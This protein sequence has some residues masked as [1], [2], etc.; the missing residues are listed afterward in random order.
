[1]KAKIP[2]CTI[3]LSILTFL[4]SFYV[5]YDISGFFFGDVKIVQLEKYGGVTFSHIADFEIWR[6]FMSQVIHV[7]QIHMLYNV[8]SLFIIGTYIERHLGSVRLLMLWLLSGISGTLI[9]TLFVS[10]PWNLGTGGSQAIMGLAAAGAVLI[11]RR[12]DS[13]GLKIATG[14]A[15]LPAISLDIVF[16]HYPKPGHVFGFLVGIGVC[17]FF[18]NGLSKEQIR[19]KGQVG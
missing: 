19:N 6:L 13:I 3:I 4:V 11:Y 12:M 16:A 17:L 14:F 5:A 15:L 10:P 7:K 9:S 8:T 1:M 18:I 2:Y